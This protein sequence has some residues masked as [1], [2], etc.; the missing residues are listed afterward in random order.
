MGSLKNSYFVDWGLKFKD[1]I[2]E[3]SDSSEALLLSLPFTVISL[4]LHFYV[5]YMLYVCS[6]VC[7]LLKKHIHH[8]V[9]GPTQSTHLNFS[10]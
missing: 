10:I 9:L 1:N 3:R 5:L 2:L 8:V 6:H 4:H 7:P